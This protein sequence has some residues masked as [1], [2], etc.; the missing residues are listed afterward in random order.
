MPDT[1][2]DSDSSFQ[3][4]WRNAAKKVENGYSNLPSVQPRS[5]GHCETCRRPIDAAAPGGYC[6]DCYRIMQFFSKDSTGGER[7]NADEDYVT[8]PIATGGGLVDNRSKRRD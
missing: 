1:P 5:C 3:D 6:R 7:P 8:P 4:G 2:F